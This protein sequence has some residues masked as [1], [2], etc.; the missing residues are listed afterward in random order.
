MSPLSEPP[1]TEEIFLVA[2]DPDLLDRNQVRELR[3]LLGRS[4][5][6]FELVITPDAERIR[7]LRERV[8]VAAGRP[9]Y[10][11]LEAMPRLG[12]YQQWGAGADW[13]MRHP[14]AR[15]APFVLTNATGIH[16]VQITEHAFALALSLAR[17]LPR[18]F[19]SQ[20]DGGWFHAPRREIVELHGGRAL[21]LGYG[22]IGRRIAEVALCLGMHV[23]AA[24][25]TPTEETGEVRV[26]TIDALPRLLPEADVVFVAL[27]LTRET[28][29]LLGAAELA[30]LMPSSLLVN[31][32][33]GGIVDEL[34]LLDALRTGALAGA[35]LD[36]FEDEPLSADAPLRNMEN[37]IVTGHYAG[38]SPHYDRRAMTILLANL[39][40]YLQGIP[41]ENVVDKQKG[42]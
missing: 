28:K 35:G 27:P 36:V 6:S 22:S 11:L 7:S 14:G 18:A 8:V 25:R 1:K 2:K 9:P 10:A 20:R 5:R 39:E 24:K 32:G 33:R 34:A 29:G 31:I 30:L 12:W 16:S 37:V 17:L 4:Q 40:R 3:D 42:Y 21:V 41:L 38:E 23:T 19:D 26:T 13:L 15:D